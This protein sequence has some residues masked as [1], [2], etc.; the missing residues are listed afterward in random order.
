VALPESDVTAA[1]TVP[2]SVLLTDAEKVQTTLPPAGSVVGSA[3]GQVATTGGIDAAE[4]V[5]TLTVTLLTVIGAALGFATVIW[6]VT[7]LAADG[8]VRVAVTVYCTTRVS[9]YGT[10]SETPASLL[11][12]TDHT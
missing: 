5:I 2:G 10:C 12:L 11:T 3:E 4:L 8:S 7:V 6:P 1:V 9:P